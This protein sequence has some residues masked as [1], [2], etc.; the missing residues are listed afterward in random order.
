MWGPDAPSHCIS[1]VYLM[2]DQRTLVTGS[3]VNGLKRFRENKLRL[4]NNL[5][6]C[7]DE[8]KLKIIM[9]VR[10]RGGKIFLQ[11]GGGG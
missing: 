3:Q 9:S 1:S 7:F 5:S 8:N 11:M 4:N 2:R 6:K 10:I